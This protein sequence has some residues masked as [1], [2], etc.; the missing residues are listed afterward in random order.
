MLLL[1]FLKFCIYIKSFIKVGL[2]LFVF[3]LREIFVIKLD[4]MDI[5]YKYIVKYIDYNNC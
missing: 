5:R 4:I 3:I 2:L 1:K